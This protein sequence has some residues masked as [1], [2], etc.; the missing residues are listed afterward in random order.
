ML[1][2]SLVA[3][4]GISAA[5]SHAILRTTHKDHGGYNFTPTQSLAVVILFDHKTK[6]F[7]F[8]FGLSLLCLVSGMIIVN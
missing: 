5:Y 6:V 1:I 8:G 2:P 4:H 7:L 3:S